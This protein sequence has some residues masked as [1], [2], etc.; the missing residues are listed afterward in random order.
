MTFVL[1]L[2]LLLV[3]A[4]SSLSLQTTTNARTRAG[5]RERQGKQ[6]LPLPAGEGAWAFRLTTSGGFAGVGTGNIQINSEGEVIATPPAIGVTPQRASSCKSQLA[7]DELERLSRW[8]AAAN[9]SLWSAKYVEPSNL[10][11]CCD[12]IKTNVTL[13]R[14]EPGGSERTYTTFWYTRSSNL[15][16]ADL[17]ALHKSAATIKIDALKSCRK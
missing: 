15:L 9:P 13:T 4:S 12:Q 1:P 10:D 11:G 5:V 8:V 14:R 7:G 17:A 3:A 6:S 2:M 16:P